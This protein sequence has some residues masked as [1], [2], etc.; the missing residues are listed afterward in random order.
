MGM[1]LMGW[2]GIL[3]LVG[4]VCWVVIIIQAFKVNAT[5]G[6]LSLCIAPYALYFAFAKMQH[7]KKGMLLGGMLGGYILGAVLYSVGGA[8]MAS[9]AMNDAMQNM[10]A[11]H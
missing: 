6:I 3:S 4:F 11:Q 10:P 9:S 2:G 1:A 7:A 8:M 5:T